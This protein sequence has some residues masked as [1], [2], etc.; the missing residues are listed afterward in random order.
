[1]RTTRLSAMFVNRKSRDFIGG[2]DADRTRDLLNAIQFPPAAHTIPAQLIPRN[3]GDSAFSSWAFLVLVVKGFRT[4]I[5]TILRSQ[6]LGGT[7]PRGLCQGSEP[8]PRT[9]S[10]VG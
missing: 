1:M 8:L 7:E 4:K 10:K 6:R 9:A 5:R 2:A 3:T